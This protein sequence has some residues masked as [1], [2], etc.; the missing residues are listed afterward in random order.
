MILQTLQ[1]KPP[2]T[3]YLVASIF[4]FAWVLGGL[5]LAFLY[6]PDLRA[7]LS[8]GPAG[9]PAM[10]GLAAFVLT[11]V[12]FFYLLAHMVL[13]LAGTPPDCAID[14]GRRH[15]ARRA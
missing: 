13:A 9:I 2:R 4:A 6:L 7:V 5:I 1:R 14:G 3:S 8:Q 11:P 15:A 12:V 10:I